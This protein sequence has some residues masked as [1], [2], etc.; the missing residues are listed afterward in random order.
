MTET[1]EDFDFEF[2]GPSPPPDA[3]SKP[4]DEPDPN[5][6]KTP[7]RSRRAVAYQEKVDGLL[8][9]IFKVAAERPGNVADAATIM[10]SGPELAE[11]TGDLA[12]HDERIRKGIDWFLEGTENPYIA[13]AFVAIPF[14][15]QIYRNHEDSANP[16]AVVT[17]FRQNRETAKANAKTRQFKIPF[18]NRRIQFRLAFHFPSLHAITNEPAKLTAHV[19]GNPAV[20]QT[21]IK[22]GIKLAWEPSV[23]GSAS[24][25]PRKR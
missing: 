2:V 18:T 5:F 16:R 11:K 4:A 19:F 25:R 6:A 9:G 12:D 10:L 24:P 1:A 15:L 22:E 8:R 21:L 3:M 14:A 20:Q 7:K 13:F 23:N 17:A